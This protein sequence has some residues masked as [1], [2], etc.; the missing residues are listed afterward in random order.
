MKSIKAKIADAATRALASAIRLPGPTFAKHVAT[1]LRDRYSLGSD[2]HVELLLPDITSPHVD[3]LPLVERIYQAYQASKRDYASASEVFRP[4]KMWESWIADS[5]GQ[6]D[7]ATVA[8]FH[9]FLSNFGCCKTFT[10]FE[11]SHFIDRCHRDLAMN[12]LLRSFAVPKMISLW[13]MD[14]GSDARLESFEVPMHGNMAGVLIDGQPFP[15]NAFFD[16]QC[17]GLSTSCLQGGRANVGEL[18]GGYGG[19]GFFL[20]QEECVSTYVGFDLPEVSA[21]CAYYLTKSFPEKKFCLYGESSQ[22]LNELDDYDA[23]L[24]PAFCL[25]SASQNQFGVFFNRCSLSEMNSETARA[26]LNSIW[27]SSDYFWH[28]NHETIRNEFADGKSSLLNSE[29]DPPPT[30]Q[31]LARFR[32]Q[33]CLP[34]LLEMDEFDYFWYLYGPSQRSASS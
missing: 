17:A 14:Q 29:Y 21:C 33:T 26:F 8:G 22:P 4:S 32:E 3:E 34:F 2:Y 31:T 24:L 6:F 9:R 20:L 10:G 23:V 13:R 19:L 30:K 16:V 11:Y 18:G 27:S 5:F 7:L 25:P 15:L 1:G 12:H 28:L